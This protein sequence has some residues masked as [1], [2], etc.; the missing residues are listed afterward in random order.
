MKSVYV[1]HIGWFDGN[2]AVLHTYP[3]S[4]A[5]QKYVEFMGGAEELIKKA[6]KSFQ[7]GDYRWVAEVMNHLVFADPGNSIARNLQ[8]DALEQLGYQAEFGPWRNF[9]LSGAQELRYGVKVN[10]NT[11]SQNDESFLLSVPIDIF[12]DYMGMLLKG[13]EVR[14]EQA[15]IHVF[16]KDTNEK[17][18]LDMENGAL[19]HTNLYFMQGSSPDLIISTTRALFYGMIAGIAAGSITDPILYFKEKIEDGKIEVEG[20]IA[21]FEY[22]LEHL[23]TLDPNFNIVEPIAPGN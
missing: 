7:D 8:A 18:K 22:I 16:F 20:D 9:Y 11:H 5:G 21:K 10:E 1:K 19:N 17:Y 23:Q 3:P 4:E 2:P 13:W 15:V 14:N 6:Q 12:Y